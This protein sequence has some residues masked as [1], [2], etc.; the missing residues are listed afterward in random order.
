V[1]SLRQRK[2]LRAFCKARCNF[3]QYAFAQY[4]AKLFRVRVGFPHDDMAS[5][6]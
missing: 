3:S 1:L 6:K 4:N 5:M 2:R